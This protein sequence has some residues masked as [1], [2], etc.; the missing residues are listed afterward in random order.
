MKNI[1][2]IGLGKLGLCF[3]LTLEKAGYN[4]LGCDIDESYVK[5]INDKTLESSEQGVEEHLLKSVNLKATTDL[6]ETLNFSDIIF[7]IVATPS[8]ENGRYDHTQVDSVVSKLISFGKPEKQKHFVVC[9]TTMPQYCDSVYEKLKNYNYSVSYNP[10]FIAQ[11]TILKDQAYPDMVLIGEGNKEAGDLIQEV[12]ENITLN[13]PIFN[14]MSLT[15]AEI[16]KISL[17]CFLTTKISF[18]NMIGD[19]AK[20]SGCD[21]ERIL[22]AIGSESRISPKYLKYGYGY[23]GPCFPRDNRALAIYAAEKGVDA[24]ISLAS[25]K[26]NKAHLGYQVELFKRENDISREVVFNY[27]TYKPQ[28]TMLVESQQ[29]LF[30]KELADSGF[31]VVINERKSVVKKIKEIYGDLFT[32]SI[33]S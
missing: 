18:A 29:L 11:G 33:R 22:S 26:F 32:Y 1:S 21:P 15:E 2:I 30:A 20:F 5:S 19:I 3:G 17:N 4:V 27:V 10:E 7:V 8:L 12:Y 13:N 14:R 23:G 6:N 28:S 24:E 31:K 16:C 25:D 9:C